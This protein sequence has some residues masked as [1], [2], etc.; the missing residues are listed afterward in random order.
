MSI[1]KVYFFIKILSN[2]LLCLGFMSNIS[3]QGENK[4][5]VFVMDFSSPKTYKAQAYFLTED[6][7]TRIINSKKYD[8]LPRG[9]YSD[10]L[11]AISIENEIFEIK[12]LPVVLKDSL[13]LKKTDA[14]FFGRLIHDTGSGH[15]ELIV[16]LQY[17][18]LN[19]PAIRKAQ[20]KIPQG[21]IKYDKARKEAVSQLLLRLY[22]DE[23]LSA[24][25]DELEK[26]LALK[27]E[28]LVLKR[29]Q[30]DFIEN[31]LKNYQDRVKE[32][33][34]IY[35]SKINFLFQ[36]ISQ[37]Q[38]EP[39]LIEITKKV[40]TFNS[41]YDDLSQ[42]RRKYIFD[43]GVQWGDKSRNNLQNVYSET[44]DDFHR[45][46]RAVMEGIPIRINE[47]KTE[48][49]SNKRKKNEAR[50]IVIDLIEKDLKYLTEDYY[51]EVRDPIND[52]LNS[53]LN[54]LINES[55]NK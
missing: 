18:H 51:T 15:F 29:E 30:L 25:K 47:F 40:D 50:E 43:F 52:L 5:R 13:N 22:A 53:L 19:K 36:D 20:V 27:K 38:L 7:E 28:Q 4:L 26:E 33:I 11:E 32:S 31:K 17:L 39:H 46:F 10:I 23:I 55:K 24:K 45:K 2:C 21:A 49:Y 54:E 8:V 16:K 44:L 14:V 48:K 34:D 41:V 42:N 6:F 9:S 3:A 37:T 12:D 35:I 1:K